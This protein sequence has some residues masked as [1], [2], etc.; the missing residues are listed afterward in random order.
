MVVSPAHVVGDGVKGFPKFDQDRSRLRI[1]KTGQGV[2]NCYAMR[3]NACVGVF[4][5]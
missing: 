5:G 3:Y 2:V 4:Q 1:A